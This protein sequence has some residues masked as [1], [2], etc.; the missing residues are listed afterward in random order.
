MTSVSSLGSEPFVEEGT[1]V[2]TLVVPPVAAMARVA[3]LTASSVATLGDLTVDDIDD[4]KIAVSELITL[5]IQ[6]DDPTEITL[7]FATS[8]LDFSIEASMAV[9]G[10][11]L[12]GPEALLAR[13]VLEAVCDSYDADAVDGRIVARVVKARSGQANFGRG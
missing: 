12:Q 8:E 10:A 5:F 2:V 7:R 6:H 11:D 3:R 9:S 4:I 1:H 13:A